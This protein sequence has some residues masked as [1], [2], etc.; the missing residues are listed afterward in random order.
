MEHFCNKNF[1]LPVYLFSCFPA[2]PGCC[3]PGT[4]VSWTFCITVILITGML[5]IHIHLDHTQQNRDSLTVPDQ[6][7]A[8]SFNKR[9]GRRISQ[10]DATVICFTCMFH[11]VLSA[12]IHGVSVSLF[13]CFTVSY[14]LA[15][16]I[17]LHHVLI[18][19]R[20][21]S[22]IIP[23][24]ALALQASIQ[25]S[26][27]KLHSAHASFFCSG[28]PILHPFNCLRPLHNKE[29]SDNCPDGSDLPVCR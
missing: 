16:I 24:K 14:I 28:L 20:A 21:H 15:V 6:L 4:S 17:V 1:S 3:T 29:Y 10:A 25:A 2:D 9:S 13:P 22:C 27:A 12:G 5:H 23:D 7:T 26:C 19:H 18:R 8:H 11:A